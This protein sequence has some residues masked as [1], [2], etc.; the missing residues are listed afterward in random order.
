MIHKWNADRRT[1]VSKNGD[2]IGIKTN[3]LPQKQSCRFAIAKVLM[4]SERTKI[5]GMHP[6]FKPPT[7]SY[8]PKTILA[9]PAFGGMEAVTMLTLDSLRADCYHS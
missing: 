3:G 5:V 7:N 9:A 4:K 2:P 6:S 8:N 1:P